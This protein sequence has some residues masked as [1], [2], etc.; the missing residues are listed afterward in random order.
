MYSIWTPHGAGLLGV[1][2][3]VSI[4]IALNCSSRFIVQLFIEFC[5]KVGH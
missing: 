5:S 3:S 2:A 1:H 4:F